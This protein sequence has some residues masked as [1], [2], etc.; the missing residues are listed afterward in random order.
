MR[1]AEERDDR[2][3]VERGLAGMKAHDDDAHRSTD[4]S[5]AAAVLEAVLMLVGREES[6]SAARDTHHTRC[7]RERSTKPWSAER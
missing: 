7:H 1:R 3:T 2:A 6:G 5:T 4:D